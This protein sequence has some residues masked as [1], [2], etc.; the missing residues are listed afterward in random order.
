M[1]MKY[2][3]TVKFGQKQYRFDKHWHTV[4]DEHILPR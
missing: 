1:Y 4:A 3:S 2:K